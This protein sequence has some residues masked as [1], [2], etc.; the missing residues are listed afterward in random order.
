MKVDAEG[1]LGGFTAV[2]VALLLLLIVQTSDFPMMP[3]V[4]PPETVDP[5]DTTLGQR[6]SSFLWKYR[7]L[8]IVAQAVL[9]FTSAI[10]C[11]AML[12]RAQERR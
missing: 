1:F 7:G 11:L 5:G 3:A 4:Y 9:L 8:D 12:R 2:L 10:G 6:M